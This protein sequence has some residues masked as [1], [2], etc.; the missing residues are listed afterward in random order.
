LLTSLGGFFAQA[1]SLHLVL[2][3]APGE[4][5]RICRLTD[6]AVVFSKV[7]GYHLAFTLAQF[8][9]E[10]VGAFSLGSAGSGW[11]GG[12][13]HGKR[14]C[15]RGAGN[16]QSPGPALKRRTGDASDFFRTQ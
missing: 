16:G 15:K 6:V 11:S 14:L 12:L 10:H 5:K 1:V 4:A 7:L 3:S 2:K 9:S 8:Y 13:G